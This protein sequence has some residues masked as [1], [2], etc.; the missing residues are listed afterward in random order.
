[1]LKR[2]SS[3][4]WCT[5]RATPKTAGSRTWP[6][7]PMLTSS[8]SAAPTTPRG[9]APPGKCIRTGA[10]R[11]VCL[12]WCVCVASFRAPASASDFAFAHLLLPTRIHLTLPASVSL[13]IS[14]PDQC[15]Y[16]DCVHVFVL[17]N[18]WPSWWTTRLPRAASSSSTPRTP[19]S[20]A[21]QAPRNRFTKSRG[22]R[23]APLR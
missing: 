4:T 11:G 6:S 21:H 15:A 17:G 2:C 1:M 10:C 18:S 14:P 16:S 3:R 23:S 5:C 12:W 22:R 13:L 20:S 7:C 8:T 19:L 9:P